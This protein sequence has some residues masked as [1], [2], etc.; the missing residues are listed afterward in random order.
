MRDVAIIETCSKKKLINQNMTVRRKMDKLTAIVR[1][2]IRHT[3]KLV[4]TVTVASI[5]C[6]SLL[7][8]NIIL[9]R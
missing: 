5:W 6:I 2:Q 3:N 7:G 4:E 1:T 9:T 8:E